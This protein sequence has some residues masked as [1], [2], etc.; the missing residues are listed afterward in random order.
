MCARLPNREKF[1]LLGMLTRAYVGVPKEKTSTT[2]FCQVTAGSNQEAAVPGED[3]DPANN[4]N[5]WSV[6]YTCTPHR[7]PRDQPRS[8]M[9][10]LRHSVYRA[11]PYTTVQSRMYYVSQVRRGGQV[12]CHKSR[13]GPGNWKSATFASTSRQ[14]R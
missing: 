5:G 6:L 7:E 13:W 14:G 3:G 2:F 9:Y 10:P 1:W 12:H 4:E 11:L 8:G